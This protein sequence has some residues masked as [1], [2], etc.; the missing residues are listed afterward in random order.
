MTPEELKEVMEGIVKEQ[1][2]PVLE[3]Q[4][5]QDQKQAAF[6]ETNRKYAGIFD[7]QNTKTDEKKEPGLTFTRAA[8]CLMLAKNDPE[9]ALYYAMGK[10]GNSSTGM[11]PEDKEVKEMLKALSVT[12]PSEGGFLVP[13]AYSRDIVPLLRSKIA[14]MQLGVRR[15]PMSNGNMNIPKQTG[16]ATSYYVGENQDATKSQPTFGNIKLSSKK[17]ITLVPISNDLIRNASVEAD[18]LV[19]DDMVQVMALKVDHTAMYGSGTEFT[20]RGIKTVLTKEATASITIATGATTLTADIPGSM[21]AALMTNN[22]PMVSVGWA[23]NSKIWNA[24]YNLKTTTNQ[25]IYRDEMNR[26]NLN[27]FPFKVTNQ[28]TTANSTA[29]TTYFD[30]F[31]GD[32]SEFLFGEEMAFEL[33]ASREASWSDG[34]S[35]QSAFSLDQ[36]VLKVTQKHDMGLRHPES[37]LCWNYPSQ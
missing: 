3:K 6:E 27:G 12:T 1:L 7:Q 14:V 32:F 15:V 18:T 37:F 28:I 25:Y 33:D 36:T 19:R 16:G 13:E 35:L 24:F 11:Y 2:A 23:F 20:P 9:K 31:F 8:K 22:A 4:K 10:E 30:I 34:T 17:L 26:G 5:E 21:I 29:G